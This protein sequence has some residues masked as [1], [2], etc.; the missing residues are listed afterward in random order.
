MSLVLALANQY[1]VVMSADRR[2]TTKT[3]NRDDELTE[4]DF[5]DYT[6]KIFITKLNHGIAKTGT[7]LLKNNTPATIVIQDAIRNMPDDITD[8]VDEL[9]YIKSKL[10]PLLEE[11]QKVVLIC[12]CIINGKRLILSTDTNTNEILNNTENNK[13]YYAIKSIGEIGRLFEILKRHSCQLS[14]I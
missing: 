6:R 7:E 9:N 2:T 1:G 5:S 14:K 8:V 4:I 13:G 3:F 11:Q 12:A 10:Q